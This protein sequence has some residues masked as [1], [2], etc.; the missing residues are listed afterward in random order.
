MRPNQ[1]DRTRRC[2][3]A[4]FE[5]C[6]KEECAW[7]VETHDECS[8]RTIAELMSLSAYERDK[9]ESEGEIVDFVGIPRGMSIGIG[10]N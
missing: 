9:K 7:W 3:M 2:P 5:D 8:F 4:A 1:Y 10:L 6:I